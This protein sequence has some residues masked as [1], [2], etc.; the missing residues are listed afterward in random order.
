MDELIVGVVALLEE[1]GIPAVRRFPTGNMPRL[2][3]PKAAVE[4]RSMKAV[5]GG[6]CDYLGTVEDPERGTLERYGKRVG[7]SVL[8]RIY[9]PDSS[10]T[11]AAAETAC[12]LLS[13][14]SAVAVEE[15]TMGETVFDPVCDCYTRDVTAAFSAYLHALAADE[16]ADFLDFKLEGEI[17]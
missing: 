13:G 16:D 15:V 10:R 9:G 17:R 11:G 5:P 3:E 12:V 4:L 2:T 14:L 7:G 8:C 1:A 6:F